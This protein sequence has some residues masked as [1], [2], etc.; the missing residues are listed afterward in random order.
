MVQPF[1][2]WARGAPKPATNLRISVGN[3]TIREGEF[4]KI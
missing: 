4:G 1:C 2:V 3:S